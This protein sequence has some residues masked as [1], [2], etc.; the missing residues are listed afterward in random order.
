MILNMATSG[1][2]EKA[3]QPSQPV[4]PLMGPNPLSGLFREEGGR[5]TRRRNCFLLVYLP[6]QHR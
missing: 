2:S 3:T 5:H 1:K 4:D 6:L